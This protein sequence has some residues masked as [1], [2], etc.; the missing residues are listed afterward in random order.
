MKRYLIL[1]SLVLFN[2]TGCTMNKLSD[3]KLVIAHRG[4]S[5]YLPEHSLAAKAM[6][7]AMDADYIEQDVVMTKDDYLVILHDPYLDRVTD[8]MTVFPKRS[9]NVFGQQRWL[10]IDFTLAEIQSL[11]MT[12]SFSIDEK[13]KKLALT[14]P[15]RFPL[16][17]STFTIST[18][19]EELELIQGLN[20]STGKNI[21]IYVE[22]KAPWFHHLEGKDISK[23]TLKMVKDFG[24]QSKNDKAYIQCFDPDETRRINNVL[25]P[26]LKIDLNLVLLIDEVNSGETMRLVDG[27]LEHYNID[28]MF[29][30]GAMEKI[31]EYADGIGPWKSF[32]VDDNS[33]SDNLIISSM[34]RDAHAAGMEVHPFTFRLDSGRIPKYA[35][36]FEQLLEIFLY[37]VGVDGIFT[38]FPDKA[39]DFIRSKEHP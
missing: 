34:V 26:E 21:G 31:A 3:H 37:K 16:F 11:R 17:T 6:A 24:Y 4:A 10:A 39:V 14:Y 8:V 13:T 19:A 1:L 38:D 20:K 33:E 7:Y 23:A 9:R 27:E 36:S 32:L 28:W 30:P 25:M 12:E 29:K 5:G 22:I 15:G 35:D 18:L 2:L